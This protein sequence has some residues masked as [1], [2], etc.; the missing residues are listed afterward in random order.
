[1]Q[2]FQIAPAE[3]RAM[4]LIAAIVIVVVVLVASVLVAAVN[5]SRS[6]TFDVSSEGLRVRGDFYGRFIPASQVR[7]GEARRVN[8]DVSPELR[9]RRRTLGTGMPGY[10]AGWFR[11]QNGETALVYMTDPSRA[12]YVPTSNGYAVL[13]TPQDPDRFVAALS[14]LR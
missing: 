9:P 5:G 2:S 11:L 4:W 12:V 6:S 8:F 14:S 7:G 3:L 10:S 13:V 1:M